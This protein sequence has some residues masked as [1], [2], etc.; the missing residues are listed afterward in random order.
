MVARGL[1]PEGPVDL[2]ELGKAFDLARR[3]A[4]G[5]G[6]WGGWDMVR[7]VLVALAVVALTLP[8]AQSSS[9]ERANSSPSA[10]PAAVGTATWRWMWRSGSQDV[11]GPRPGIT[12][13]CNFWNGRSPTVV[14]LA[15][16]WHWFGLDFQSDRIGYPVCGSWDGGQFDGA[17][18][19]RGT[20]W[21]VHTGDI[22]APFAGPERVF[23]YGQ[24]GD[25]PLVGDWNGDGIDTIGVRRGNTFYLRD[26]LSGG[27]AN[28]VATFG[29]ATDIPVV[30]DWDGD[31]RDTIGVVR[32]AVWYLT[33]TLGPSG[34]LPPFRFGLPTDRPIPGPY[35]SHI[36]GVVRP[37]CTGHVSCVWI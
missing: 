12:R 36:V 10:E 22:V 16:M 13:L 25:L 19:V 31:G 34:N 32:D 29:R 30:G 4:H 35:S 18:V 21:Y 28:R 9:A 7:R 2:A 33:N 37:T 26:S 20:T 3:S 17:G 23:T 6:H 27:P 11:F 8:L 24:A 15:G 5:D 1:T 14:D